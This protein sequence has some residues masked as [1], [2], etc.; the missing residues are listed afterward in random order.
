MDNT[1]FEC[2]VCRHIYDPK[3]G[4]TDSNIKP[5]TSFEEMPQDWCCPVCGAS[6]T[7]FE[8]ILE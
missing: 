3:K 5:G 4:D 1:K 7:D 6:K 2:T 8:P